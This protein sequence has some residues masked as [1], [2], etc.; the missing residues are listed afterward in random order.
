MSE[1]KLDAGS[2]LA[3]SRFLHEGGLN[4][5]E[6]TNI[7]VVAE[8]LARGY[9]LSVDSQ[10][11][12]IVIMVDGKQHWW[13]SGLTSLNS[14]LLMRITKNKDV[15]SKLLRA[16]GHPAV[17]NAAFQKGEADQAWAWSRGL[18]ELVVKPSDG[19]WGA[20][21]H[22]G[23]TSRRQFDQAFNE[24]ADRNQAVL[25]ERRGTGREYRFVVVA[26]K[27]VA[28]TEMR[29]ANVVG[30]GR[31]KISQLIKAKNA[32]RSKTPIHRNLLLGRRENELLAQRGLGPKSVPEVD[33]V[34]YL[35]QTTNLQTMGE[36]V[37]ATDEVSRMHKTAI[38]RAAAGLPGGRLLG[39]D[40]L[41]DGS[42]PDS[43]QILEVNS[44]PMI[45]I[46]HLPLLGQPRDVAG[47]VLNTMFSTHMYP[48]RT[49]DELQIPT[50]EILETFRPAWPRA[51]RIARKV[52]NAL[53]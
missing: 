7:T 36:A 22:V 12:R 10:R 5:R 52:K 48:V 18:G 29:P 9:H 38:E 17:E 37:D 33:Q 44:G 47:A 8:A 28:V 53:R 25:V 40:V 34:V 42:R 19:T 11:S 41:I 23:I 51:R 45:S 21:V 24:V 43:V 39:F 1:T 31:S 4:P 46:Q 32:D 6:W 26:G 14:S 49:P 13:K 2:Y 35:R 16:Q 20:G 27:V 50:A 30:D 15:A 3:A